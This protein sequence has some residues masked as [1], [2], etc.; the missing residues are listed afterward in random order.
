MTRFE[1]CLRRGMM[2]ANIA[3]YKYAIQKA[4]SQELDASPRYFRE[5]MRLLAD[6]WGWARQ[7]EQNNQHR[8]KRLDWRL[9]AI[10]AA[11]MLL[12]ACAYAVVTGQ[13]SQWFPWRG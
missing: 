3:Q 6:P 12:S 4:E 8:G 10:I 11:L 7:R 1:D 2:D 9:I 13:F 5:R